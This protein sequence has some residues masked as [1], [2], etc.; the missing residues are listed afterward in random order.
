MFALKNVICPMIIRCLVAPWK[1]GTYFRF[2]FFLFDW[3]FREYISFVMLA[4][5]AGCITFQYRL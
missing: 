5:K 3:T 2:C 4:L 1:M